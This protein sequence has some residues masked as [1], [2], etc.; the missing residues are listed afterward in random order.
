MKKIFPHIGQIADP[1]LQQTL[2]IL[3]DRLQTC[4]EELM[5]G[6]RTVGTLSRVASAIPQVTAV[7]N[8]HESQITSAATAASLW[9]ST[10]DGTDDN[11]PTP[12]PPG[13]GGGLTAP[14]GLAI[15]A[16]CALDNPTEFS[17][18]HQNYPTPPGPLRD[19]AEAFIRLVVP[20]LK[21][22]DSEFYLN[23]KANQTNGVISQDAVAYLPPTGDKEVYDIIFSAGSPQAAPAWN[24]VGYGPRTDVQ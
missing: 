13:G 7:V 3:W 5:A 21:T 19:A 9:T 1:N 17:E 6:E 15:V 24:F 8:R 10:P 2:R 23:V 11:A 20:K 14:N 22:L 4:E 16:Q 12:V 18:A